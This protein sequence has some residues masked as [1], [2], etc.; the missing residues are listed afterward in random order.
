M[1]QSK[2]AYSKASNFFYHFVD[3]DLIFWNFFL[4]LILWIFPSH[5]NVFIESVFFITLNSVHLLT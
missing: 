5:V 1:S 4:F 2:Q 3:L